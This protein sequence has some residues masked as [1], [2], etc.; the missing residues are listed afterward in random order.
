MQYKIYK[1]A[2]RGSVQMGWL[3]AKHSFSFG[4]WYN[5]E[6]IHFGVL[7]VLNDDIVAPSGGFGMH[8][9]DN[10]EIVT[11]PLQGTLEHKDSMGNTGT[12]TTGEI[13]VMSA[14]SGIQHSEYNHS[15]TEEVKLLQIW[16]F[17]NQKN[18]TPRYDQYTYKNQIVPNEWLC[19]LSPDTNSNTMWLHQDAWFSILHADKNIE[20]SYTSNKKGNGLYVFVIEGNIT[21]ND[22][23]LQHRDA[24]GIWDVEK[25]SIL[26]SDQSK[27]LVMDIPMHVS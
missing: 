26:A 10:M 13:Q 15:N 20:K 22:V 12:I 23:H 2:D 18:V 4:Q 1:E 21:I 3:Q 5:A 17:P 7:R 14:G 24:L 8:P 6:Q 16:L 25:I 27:I 9:H 19:I 11:I